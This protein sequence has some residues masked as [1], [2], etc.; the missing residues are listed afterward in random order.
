[1][2]PPSAAAKPVS[3][4]VKLH[5]DA[6]PPGGGRQRALKSTSFLTCAPPTS[7]CAKGLNVASVPLSLSCTPPR[8]LNARDLIFKPPVG[9]RKSFSLKCPAKSNFNP[10]YRFTFPVT[11]VLNP[12]NPSRSSTTTVR[13]GASSP[14]PVSTRLWAGEDLK[15]LV[16]LLCGKYRS[17]RDYG[18]NQKQ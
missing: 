16:V 2:P 14:I 8:K 13:A 10:R 6:E 7:A 15:L 4:S 9:S 12:W 17:R 3:L 1:M 5:D 18:E 11:D